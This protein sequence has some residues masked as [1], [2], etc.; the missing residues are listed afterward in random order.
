MKKIITIL[1]G[2]LVAIVIYSTL[3]VGIPKLQLKNMKLSPVEEKKVT[4]SYSIKI[5][6]NYEVTLLDVKNYE[7]IKTVEFYRV[8]PS[9]FWV[10]PKPIPTPIEEGGENNIIEEKPIVMKPDLILDKEI[11]LEQKEHI[12]NILG[13]T[14]VT[15]IEKEYMGITSDYGGRLDPFTNQGAF[16]TG[17]DFSWENIEGKPIRSIAK[18]VITAIEL[19][20]KNGPNEGYGNVVTVEH[21]GF[22]SLYAHMKDIGD[23]KVGNFVQAGEEIGTVGN[24]GRS[25]GPHLHFEM[26]VGNIVINPK[27]YLV[28]IIENEGVSVDEET[29]QI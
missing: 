15:P 23:I 28:L 24:T 21:N 27:E 25:T 10:K 3:L 9:E 4:V 14:G 6:K 5:P 22:T 26:R 16:H 12:K 19:N 13:E 8:N 20:D 17:M 2:F 11:T 7:E 29:K 18:G 1:I